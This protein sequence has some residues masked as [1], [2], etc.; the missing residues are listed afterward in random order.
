MRSTWRTA[1]DH[2][3]PMLAKLGA[4]ALSGIL[5]LTPATSAF[6]Q[7]AASDDPR[8]CARIETNADR[9]ACYDRVFRAPRGAAAESQTRAIEPSATVATTPPAPPTPAAGRAV[10]TGDVAEAQERRVEIVI[11]AM[12]GTQGSNAAFTTDQGEVWIQIDGGRNYYP[13]LPFRAQIRPGAMSSYFL[14]PSDRGRAIRV[15]R[16]E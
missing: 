8:D 7:A 12:R 4:V 5:Q 11:V 6:A 16:G 1:D 13:D 14:T 3:I 9:L 10:P 2:A 15:R